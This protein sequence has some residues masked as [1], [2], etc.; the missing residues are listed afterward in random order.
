[1]GEAKVRKAEIKRLIKRRSRFLYL[2]KKY[3][4]HTDK[5]IQV[6]LNVR[7]WEKKL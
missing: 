1:M 7:I 5:E 6:A 4:R 3:T 2:C